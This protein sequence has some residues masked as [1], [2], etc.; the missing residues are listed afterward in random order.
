MSEEELI[1][2]DL[3]DDLDEKGSVAG[4]VFLTLLIF[5]LIGIT[6]AMPFVGMCQMINQLI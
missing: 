5:V 3:E 1:N 6:V 4:L 2:Y